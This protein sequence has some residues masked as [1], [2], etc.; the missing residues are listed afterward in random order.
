MINKRKMRKILKEQKLSLLKNK[1][2]NTPKYI[3]KGE[4]DGEVF[5]TIWQPFW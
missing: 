5:T 2:I 1:A 3:I 4:N